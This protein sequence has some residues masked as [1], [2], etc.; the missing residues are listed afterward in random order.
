MNNYQSIA[1][2]NAPEFINLEPL[3]INPMMS[4]CEI[5]VLYLGPNRNGTSIS[6]QVA[7]EMAKTLRGAPIVGYYKKDKQDFFDHGEQIIYDGD[8]VHFNTLTKPYGFVSPD[9]EVWFQDFEETNESGEGT[10][11]T[12]M[13]TTGYLWT[14][15]YE[16]AKQLF[17][18]GGK[19]QS[20]ELD[21]NSMQGFWAK[22]EN[23]DIEF[24]IIND[25]VFSK[26]CILGD[27]VEPCFEGASITAPNISK[28][29][30]LDDKFKRTLY[31]MMKEL[32]ETLQ[33]GNYK[34]ADEIKKQSVDS[35]EV[36]EEAVEQVSQPEQTVTETPNNEES[37]TT[38]EETT[39]TDSTETP[40][41]TTET[42]ETTSTTEST[43]GATEGSGDGD[44]AGGN[45]GGSDGGN[46]SSDYA[47]K[48]DDDEKNDKE[49][50]DKETKEDDNEE[51]E[52]DDTKKKYS[53]LVIQYEELQKSYADL[54]AKAAETEKILAQ[55]QLKAN[56]LENEKKD[57]LIAEFYMLSDEDKKDVIDHKTEYTLDEIKA[58]LAVL[59]YDKKVSYVNAESKEADNVTVNIDT[60]TAE[61][62]EW[63]QAV[64]KHTNQ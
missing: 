30:S 63:L 49:S 58:K 42:T 12:Y 29:F 57:A 47:K 36:I 54:Q 64:D 60:Y 56:E 17:M 27:D 31:S 3:D 38:T 13:M 50:E 9:A 10:S 51:K 22:P 39:T 6:K 52:D 11:R 16:E 25:A 37:T 23:S 55:F 15:Q 53:L 8:G 59:C 40:G 19:P 61:V 43:E 24:F 2:I 21:E 34:V 14:G 18:E 32:Q 41:E 28:T 48:E 62:P 7:T 45:D 26:L 44:G 33:G 4:K 1:T 35:S 46:G 5:K 20:M